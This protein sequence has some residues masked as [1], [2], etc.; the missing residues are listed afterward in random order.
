MDLKL[1]KVSTSE[2]VADD[3][4]MMKMQEAYDV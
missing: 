3:T 2:V 1:R 4:E